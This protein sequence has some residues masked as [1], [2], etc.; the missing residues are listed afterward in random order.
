MARCKNYGKMEIRWHHR[1]TLLLGL[2]IILLYLFYHT[3]VNSTQ[4]DSVIIYTSTGNFRD[5]REHKVLPSEKW[6]NYHLG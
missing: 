2:L 1:V 4:T 6:I 5:D 3:S